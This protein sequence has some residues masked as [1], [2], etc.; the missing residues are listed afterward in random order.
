MGSM[1]CIMGT[2]PKIYVAKFQGKICFSR[3]FPEL[4]DIPGCLHVGCS[5]EHVFKVLSSVVDS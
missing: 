4:W 1:Y 3:M 5:L 2:V